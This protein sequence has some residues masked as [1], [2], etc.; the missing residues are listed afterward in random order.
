[1]PDV[2]LFYASTLFGAM[3]LAAAID[4]GR[5]PGG[6]DRVLLVSNNAAIPEITPA[7]DEAPGFAAL[8]DRFDRVLSWNEIIA[9]LHPSD[10]RP[11]SIE[12]PMLGRMLRRLIGEPAELVVES[13]AVPPS[14]TLAGLVKDCPIT[15]YAD[16][17]MSYGPTRDPLPREIAGRITRLLH[18]DLVPGL[19]PLLLAEHGV[20]AEALT[21][22]SFA[23]VVGRAAEAAEKAPRAEAVVLGQYL[24]AL[25]LVTAAEEAALHELMLRGVAARGHRTVLFKPHPA[26]ARR[27]ARELR[28]VAA[29]LGVDLLVAPAATP[30]E[31]CFAAHRPALVVGCFSTALTTARRLFG[32]PVAT[33]GTGLVLERLTPYENGNRIPA[34]IADA[35]LPRLEAD[36]T[37]TEPPAADLAAL[38]AAVGY[39]MRSAAHPGLRETAAAYVAAHGPARY[40]K[41]RRLE[42]LGLIDPPPPP[43]PPAPPERPVSRLRRLLA[44]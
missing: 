15:V 20:P 21:D 12:T 34:T 13:I 42:S 27:H 38:V 5:F 44:R 30:A 31:A 17:L 24:S 10:W 23:R 43:P 3:T 28:P 41:R 9:P 14:R 25:G 7:L 33:T 26:A 22:T 39:C 40:F 2:T 37:L 19:T 8:R 6:G 36:G 18:L 16:G 35:A 11:R 1:M 29:E 32:L 4:E